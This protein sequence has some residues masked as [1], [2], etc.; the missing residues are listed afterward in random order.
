M[1][2]GVCFLICVSAFPDRTAGADPRPAIVKAVEALTPDAVEEE[3]KNGADPNFEFWGVP[4][5]QKVLGDSPEDLFR[6][7][8]SPEE[9][10]SRI[11]KILEVL[12]ESG[13]DP[14]RRNRHG[15]TFLTA[16]VLEHGA[17]D[18]V[19]LAVHHGAEVNGPNAAGDAPIH[20]AVTR[21]SLLKSLLIHGADAG[22]AHPKTGETPLMLAVAVPSLEAVEILLEAD[23]SPRAV[24]L[25]GRNAFQHLALRVPQAPGESEP[26][27]EIAVTCAERFQ[28]AGADFRVPDEKGATAFHLAAANSA[29]GLLQW[30]LGQGNVP[31][32]AT[33][34]KGLTPLA[35]ALEAI[36]VDNIRLLLDAGAKV[37]ATGLL[38]PVA[39]AHHESR[40][41]AESYESILR[42]M[43]PLQDDPD[44]PDAEGWTALMWAAASDVTAA[45]E[46]LLEEGADPDRRAPDGRHALHFAAASGAAENVGL[47]LERGVDVGAVDA[48]GAT[49]AAWALR[50][51]HLRVAETLLAAM[52]VS[53]DAL[54]LALKAGSIAT[55]ER[56]I[57]AEPTWINA[58]FE[59][60]PPLHL[61]IEGRHLELV[62]LLIERGA[63]LIALDRSRLTPLSRAVV[64]NST[65][66]T[67]RLL[68]TD[69]NPANF[70]TDGF[71]LAAE[72]NQSVL[73]EILLN[74]LPAPLDYEGSAR[75]IAVAIRKDD[76]A[77]FRFLL[78]HK[79]L[80]FAPNEGAI[81]PNEDDAFLIA[82]RS[83]SDRYLRELIAKLRWEPAPDHP[84]LN[85]IWLAA[86]SAKSVPVAT[87]LR[88][89]FSVDVAKTATERG[90]RQAGRIGPV[91]PFDD[92]LPRDSVPSHLPPLLIAL[93]AWDL[94]MAD[95]LRGEGA[96]LEGHTKDLPML[97]TD[98]ARHGKVGLLAHVLDH[99]PTPDTGDPSLLM[100]AAA[101]GSAD[102]VA[103]LLERGADPT[104]RDRYGKSVLDHALAG[105]DTES[106]RLVREARP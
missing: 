4:L 5:V 29:S 78:H 74:S 9:R 26:L 23:A 61:A 101:S 14:N 73:L 18:F 24:D 102:C 70:E 48:E 46:F 22:L 3:L 15:Q 35:L 90:L 91:G 27:S 84:A 52:P 1:R 93:N 64:A 99:L 8:F 10:T 56:I 63:D 80:Q 88:E 57:E 34:E 62:S 39:R 55:V 59:G 89:A 12:F 50:W 58:E 43:E 83:P 42:A 85:H 79:K 106:I 77:L 36:E 7:K 69:P 49:A 19:E 38:A 16:L 75:L 95:F 6:E 71:V 67:E 2:V 51:G 65:E 86:V 94:E 20:L 105:G 32:E 41:S 72:G 54:L 47:L 13:A 53:R 103:L 17:L 87:F 28:A 37:P 33:D 96:R 66:I 82:A 100:L 104:A 97:A 44:L 40:I 30:S 21:P 11:G 68:E 60:S 81:D 76:L 98:L 45:V 25:R 31:L 92:P